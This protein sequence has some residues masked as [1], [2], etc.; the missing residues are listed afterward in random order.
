M[1]IINSNPMKIV[2]KL[3]KEYDSLYESIFLNIV[4][5]GS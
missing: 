5:L 4:V 3:N 2:R 1:N